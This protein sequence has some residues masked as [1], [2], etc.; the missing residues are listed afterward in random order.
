VHRY[1]ES[2]KIWMRW[3]RTIQIRDSALYNASKNCRAVGS[4]NPM[5]NKTIVVK[6]RVGSIHVPAKGNESDRQTEVRE[7]QESDSDG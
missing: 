7:R 6:Q 1:E 3:P 4:I 5:V 2:N